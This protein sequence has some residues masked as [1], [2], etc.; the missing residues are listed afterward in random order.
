MPGK[1]MAIDA[2]LNTGAITDAEAKRR[3][4][5]IQEEANFFGSMDG[6]VKY[7][8]GDAVAG[9][10]ITTINIVGGIIMGMTRQ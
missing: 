2:D 4:E 6:A 5:K 7:V 3:R 10:L 1:Q 9:L 8:K